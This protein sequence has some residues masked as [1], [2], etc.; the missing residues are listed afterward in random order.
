MPRKVTV[1]QI[2]DQIKLIREGKKVT[3]ES[4]AAALD[5]AKN[6]YGKIERGDIK[7]TV[8]RLIA[9]LDILGISLPDFFDSFRDHKSGESIEKLAEKILIQ[10]RTIE[11]K[12][13]SKNPKKKVKK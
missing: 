7:L 11:T 3:Q 5:L 13:T 10:I 2:C 4:M 9:I 8:E 12:E 1:S 6:N